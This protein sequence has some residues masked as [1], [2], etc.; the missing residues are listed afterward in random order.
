MAPSDAGLVFAVPLAIASSALAGVIVT[1]AWADAAASAF[2]NGQ[3]SR[4]TVTLRRAID[5]TIFADPGLSRQVIEQ[6]VWALETNLFRSATG[7]GRA[8]DALD[9]AWHAPADDAEPQT[10]PTRSVHFIFGKQF[11]TF[12]VLIRNLHT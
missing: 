2:A 6:H 10:A 5:A 12:V 1:R 4:A 8:L 11:A 3:R 9:H 7:Q